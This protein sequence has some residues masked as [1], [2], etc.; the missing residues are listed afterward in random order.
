MSDD[1]LLSILSDP[2]SPTTVQSHL[3]SLFGATASILT[4]S[5]T[6]DGDIPSV[7]GVVSAEGEKL[8][9]IRQVGTCNDILVHAYTLSY[10]MKN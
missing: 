1:S 2:T 7:T 8:N 9:L 4:T 3:G 6:Q 10:T 5:S